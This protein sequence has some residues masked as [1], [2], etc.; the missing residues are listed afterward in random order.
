MNPK[1]AVAMAVVVVVLGYNLWRTHAARVEAADVARLT[2]ENGFVELAQPNGADPRKVWI[3]AAVNCPKEGAQ[4]AD[5]LA[6]DLGER[7]V[8]FERRS[9]VS[10]S[11]E[12]DDP[13]LFRRINAMLGGETPI[14]FVNG[15]IKANPALDDVLAEYRAAQR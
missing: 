8:A 6:R 1:F 5:A 7:D 2:D 3:V 12:D 11:F 13:V 10:F 14:V 15:R 9:G 4:R